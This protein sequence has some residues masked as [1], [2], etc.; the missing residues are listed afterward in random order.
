MNEAVTLRDALR[1]AR[2]E[3]VAV[4]DTPGLDA[5]VLLCHV[6]GLDTAA[7]L[8]NDAARLPAGQ[9]SRFRTL[10]ERRVAGEPIAHL[11]GERE[12]WSLSFRVSPRTLIPRPDTETLVQRALER[13]PA[14]AAW[15][16]L[17]LGT[18]TGNVAVALAVERPTCAVT[19][20]DIDEG[21]RAVAQDN[22]RRL[23]AGNVEVLVGNWFDAV[24]DRRFELV[25][26]N[27]P[28]VASGDPHLERGDVAQEPRRALVSGDDG[29]DDIRA[30]V[31]GAAAHLEPGGWL[32]LE[33]GADQ[34]AAVRELFEAAGFSRVETA[35]D[36]GGLERVTSGRH[37]D[38]SRASR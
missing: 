31:A 37:G 26:S 35:A 18:G 14:G 8:R 38:A 23:G 10:V 30:I 19:A 11:T 22:A 13:I 24:A 1:Q 9:S 32:M 29:L 5:E 16:L 17:D 4:S 12:F 3:L 36:L 15:R 27:P 25:V 28:Y 20:V 6:T 34:G 2:G 33:H 21:T 7:L